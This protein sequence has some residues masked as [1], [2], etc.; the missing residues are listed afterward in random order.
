T[1]TATLVDEVLTILSIQAQSKGLTL[2]NKT[3]D[4][5][6]LLIDPLRIK[7][8]I[9]NVI[10]NAIKFTDAGEITITNHCDETGHNISITDT[11]IGMTEEQIKI[12]LQPFRQVHG[13][14]LARRYQGTGLGLSFS[15]KIMELHDG[16][17]IVTGTLDTGST[18]TLH[19]PP[20]AT[21][22]CDI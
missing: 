8:V 13:T 18:I 15:Q 22:G 14:A 11:G 4:M 20:E 9:L 6:K 16:A 10:G 21:E 2:H 1:F 17:L 12:A 19:F 7:Q 3:H 5:H